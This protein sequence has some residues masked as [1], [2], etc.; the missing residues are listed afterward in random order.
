MDSDGAVGPL[1][2]APAAPTLDRCAKR[3]V[4]EM[5]AAF[6]AAQ[7]RS[8]GLVLAIVS[9]AAA[10][11]PLTS[12][13]FAVHLVGSVLAAAGLVV[14]MAM[15][16]RRRWIPAQE[17]LLW[18]ADR[19]ADMFWEIDGRRTT[20]LSNEEILSRVQGKT[21][22]NATFER[23]VA[24]DASG[25]TPDAMALLD[26]WHP[27]DP[28]ERCRRE[29]LAARI[30]RID[31]A[32]HLRLAQA[33]IAEVTDPGERTAQQA[34]LILDEARVSRNEIWPGLDALA[35]ARGELG[36]FYSTARPISAR[37]TFALTASASILAL[38]VGGGVLYLTEQTDGALLAF[39]ACVVGSVLLTVGL[40]RLA[41]R[42][43]A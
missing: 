31:S 25:R 18:Q 30:D 39:A 17:M 22:S 37:P 19:V 32:A 27:T 6:R 5:R 9:V 24:L 2:G 23:V 28:V 26:S 42:N 3:C 16:G 1:G 29:R 10:A 41:R 4:E 12:S 8:I 35:A 33:A 38:I 21:G 40:R 11:A 14:C 34:M 43:A 20:P 13:Q 36:P 7:I 15:L